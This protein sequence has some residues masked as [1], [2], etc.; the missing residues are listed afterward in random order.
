[1][2][3][4]KS[5]ST[6]LGV[7]LH[8]SL[9]GS[10][11]SN[12]SLFYLETGK[13]QKGP[14]R[15]CGIYAK[16]SN[17]INPEFRFSH[18]CGVNVKFFRRNLVLR[19]ESKLKCINERFSRSKAL[20]GYLTPVWKEGLLLIRASIYTAVISGICLLVWFGQN[21]A[22]GFI[23]AKL[24]P[25]VCSAISE[26]IQRDL[27]FGKVR[28]I[29]PLS[30][31]LESC[32]IGPHKEE[33]SCGEAPSV[34]LRLR[35][36]A[37]LRRGKWVIDAV[38]SNPSVLV[39][40]KKDFTWLG[41]P[42]SEG[43]TQ[44]HLSNEEGI[45]HRT[46]TRRLAREEA[47]SRWAR[48]RDDAAREAAE[49]GYFVSERSVL[50]EDDGLKEIATPST[51]PVSTKSFFCMNEEKYDHHCMDTGVEYDTKH[52]N[53][54][55]S[56]GV[57]LPGSGLRFWSKVMKRGRTPKFKRKANGSDICASGITIKRRIFE[58]SALAAR[59]YFC[60]PNG[61][62]GEALS[63]SACF[64]SMNHNELLVK[65]ETNKN[66]KPVADGD[67]SRDGDSHNATQAR[68][69]GIWSS[70][71]SEN[72]SGHSDYVDLDH[73]LTLKTKDIKYDNLPSSGDVIEPVNVNS[74]AEEN[75]ELGRD[76]AGK[77]IDDNLPVFRRSL[78]FESSGSVKPTPSL[79]TFLQVPI[80]PMILK[81]GL[82][83]LFRNIEES[84]THFLSGPV[85]NL[86]SIVGLKVEDIVAEHVDD[87]DVQQPEGITNTLP[88]T[89]DSV[90]F[91]GAT[92]MLLAYGDR[93]VR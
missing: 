11:S 65:S 49:L 79:A 22:K 82:T 4:V 43:V 48:E 10:S 16:Q 93:E 91:R 60:G 7:K 12:R 21:K 75:E 87:I 52:A 35:P 17:P 74:C 37:S 24:L 76:V 29:S 64:H 66:V 73:D 13:L 9:G 84:L 5:H 89:L 80:K 78:S 77:Q 86:K 59:A 18:F 1:M 8:G 88:V 15:R 70:T 42:Q 25:S 39:A 38:L 50:S 32:S 26:Y 36:F 47:G 81:F 68:D 33:F 58:R 92:I 40:Q 19:S 72:I 45:D 63:P 46:K 57:K 14:G 90:H 85:Q 61:K 71:T 27:E 67:E 62:F 31:T 83:S 30:I 2:L 51:E 28:S 44:R 54:E 20:L 53:L 56:F 23:E 55:K 34:K 69:L 6:F 41:L 3:S